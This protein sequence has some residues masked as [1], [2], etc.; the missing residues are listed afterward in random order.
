MKTRRDL[1]PALFG[2]VAMGCSLAAQA[3]TTSVWENVAGGDWG[4]ATNWSTGTV[5][6][7][8]SIVA[9]FSTLS[10]TSNVAVA[11]NSNRS[12][13]ALRFGSTGATNHITVGNTGNSFTIGAS[14]VYSFFHVENGSATINNRLLAAGGLLGTYKTGAGTVR[15]GY[16]AG[17]NGYGSGGL[18]LQEGTAQYAVNSG[19]P[20]AQGV[21]FD[22]GTLH[23]GFTNGVS[24]S[25]IFTVN[26]GTLH[27]TG[28]TAAEYRWNTADQLRGSGTLNVTGGGTLYIAASQSTHFTGTLNIGANT[29]LRMN[30]STMNSG[31]VNLASSAQFRIYSSTAA[32][33][34]RLTGTG[35]VSPLT[36]AASLTVGDNGVT[37]FSFDGTVSG[38]LNLTKT[39]SSTMTLSGTN[40]YLGTTDINAGKLLVNG[41]HTGGGT[42]TV[43]SG[44]SL[45]GGG[46]ISGPLVTVETGGSIEPG[47]SIGQLTVSSLSLATASTSVFE[48]AG[49]DLAGTDFDQIK[50]TSVS[51][52]A[53]WVLELHFQGQQAG[54]HNIKLF[55]F[56]SY[57]GFQAPTVQIASGD[58]TDVSF[59][60]ANG[61]LT[62]TQVIPE[63]TTA[64]LVLLGA[65][66]LPLSR[67]LRR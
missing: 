49:A 37:P 17:Q 48:I 62:Y 44:A 2:L 56:S 66:L 57:A 52:A 7:A 51:S 32:A 50:G 27:L 15:F 21:V 28:G 12:I 24:Q 59:N 19:N 10:Y 53:G 6:A 1:A 45:G 33:V 46:L 47:N 18:I 55:D 36:G 3:Q 30:T 16:F 35:T 9:D 67:T 58:A 4:V 5:P 39:G 13:R 63:P 11:Q 14:G 23:Y 43:A 54:T 26:S 31:T 8:N 41:E 20:F 65:V 25:G 38:S 61:I 29:K 34:G 42:Y 64:L 40:S 60:S 22:G